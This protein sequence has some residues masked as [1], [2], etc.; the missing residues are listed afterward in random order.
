MSGLYNS[1]GQNGLKCDNI[2]Q[3]G[4]K[5]SRAVCVSIDNI[6]IYGVSATNLMIDEVLNDR[7][8]AGLNLVSSTEDPLLE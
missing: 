3:S 4:S 6:I 7:A 8:S 5:Q 2:N 1:V